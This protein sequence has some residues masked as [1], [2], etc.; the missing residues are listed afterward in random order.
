MSERP[1]PGT[2]VPE[3][4]AYLKTRLTDNEL[5]DVAQTFKDGDPEGSQAII[6][7]ANTRNDNLNKKS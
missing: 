5:R 2:G 6:N 1:D 3:L 7:K 4:D